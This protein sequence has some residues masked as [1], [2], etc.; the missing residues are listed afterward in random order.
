[1]DSFAYYTESDKMFRKDDL[2]KFLDAL[3]DG[4]LDD[5][6]AMILQLNAR[7][8]WDN[9]IHIA[10]KPEE[11]KEMPGEIFAVELLERGQFSPFIDK[12]IEN[13]INKK[14]KMAKL[15]CGDGDAW[16][17]EPSNESRLQI[18]ENAVK[19]GCDISVMFRELDAWT[20]KGS[21]ERLHNIGVSVYRVAANRSY[22]GGIIG[23]DEMYAIHRFPKDGATKTLGVSQN[24]TEMNYTF[25]ATNC[26]QFVD[27]AK[28]V[29]SQ[30]EKNTTPYEEIKNNL[31]KGE[32]SREDIIRLGGPQSA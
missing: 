12:R 17:P 19:A 23:D 13:L 20:I 7:G 8:Y 11:F 21:A 6:P 32:A 25:L 2:D 5:A 10:R 27:K 31:A 1:L 14:K 29:I 30:L 26:P 24:P 15:I 18:Y 9:S 28:E 22:H 16:S 3:G 4:I